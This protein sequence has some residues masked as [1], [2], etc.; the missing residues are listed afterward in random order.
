LGKILKL[1]CCATILSHN[2]K[3]FFSGLKLLANSQLE[4]KLGA[5]HFI[6]IYVAPSALAAQWLV[7]NRGDRC[8]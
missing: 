2:T 5:K 6:I 8:Y 1:F 3:H 7:E 4:A